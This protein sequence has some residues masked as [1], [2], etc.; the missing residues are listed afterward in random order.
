M[1]IHDLYNLIIESSH[2]SFTGAGI[3]FISK[4]KKM[5]VLKKPNSVWCL[6]GG[7]PEGEETP[8]QTA[9]RE[10]YE[11]TGIYVKRVSSPLTLRYKDKTYFSFIHILQSEQDVILSD[12]H[13]DYKWISLKN[14]SKIKLIPPFKN[15]AKFIIKEINKRL[16]LNN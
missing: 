12:E 9:I 11:E 2:E 1:N 15:N 6:P 5:L 8:D 7:K 3:I 10:T 13:K 14:I 4:D 16:R